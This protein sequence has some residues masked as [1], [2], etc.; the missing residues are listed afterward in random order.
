M[1]KNNKKQE[2]H[3]LLLRCDCGYL[4][5]ILSASY[6]YENELP[7]II[8]TMQRDN[9]QP[10]RNRVE[11]LWHI[12]RGHESFVGEVVLNEEDMRKLYLFLRPFVEVS[13]SG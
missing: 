13:D 8:I 10:F 11:R 3:E 7:E 12:F 6:Y 9:Q 1:R 4:L 5:H 2:R